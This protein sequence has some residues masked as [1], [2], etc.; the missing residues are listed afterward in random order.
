MSWRLELLGALRARS[1]VSDEE[2]GARRAK[3]FAGTQWVKTGGDARN[4]RVGRAASALCR[5]AGGLTLTRRDVERGSEHSRRIL[6]RLGVRLR[7]HD[8]AG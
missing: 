8:P 7:N 4:D 5:D 1:L 2:V 3:I 6:G